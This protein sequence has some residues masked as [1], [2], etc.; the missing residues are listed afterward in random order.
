MSSSQARHTNICCLVKHADIERQANTLTHTHPASLKLMQKRCRCPLPVSWY[1]LW[2]KISHIL[3]K[4]FSTF[5]NSWSKHNYKITW[6]NHS[7][8][9]MDE[10]GVGA[11]WL[12]S[13]W[14]LVAVLWWATFG[15]LDMSNSCTVELVWSGDWVEEDI[16]SFD[17]WTASPIRLSRHWAYRQEQHMEEYKPK[18]RNY[19]Q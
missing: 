9:L 19:E 15:E 1:W 13:V 2:E 16:S 18:Q 7:Y 12:V 14:V 8:M 11:V 10:T 4:K 6:P 17:N 5:T 3:C